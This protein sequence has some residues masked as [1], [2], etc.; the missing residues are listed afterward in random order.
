M[1]KKIEEK[2]KGKTVATEGVT[3]DTMNL[4][5]GEDEDSEMQESHAPS[6]EPTTPLPII[7]GGSMDHDHAD[8]ACERQRAARVA[9]INENI[10]DLHAR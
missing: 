2:F 6:S 1:E 9:S 8:V 5:R 3:G 4:T 7:E 10:R